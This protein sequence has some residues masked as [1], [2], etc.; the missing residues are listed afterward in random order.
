MSIC[1]Y[2]I[3]SY[4]THE[5]V[6]WDS[7]P[8]TNYHLHFPLVPQLHAVIQC[9]IGAV[10]LRSLGAKLPSAETL[11]TCLSLCFCG[12]FLNNLPFCNL[13]FCNSGKICCHTVPENEIH[14][15]ERQNSDLTIF[16][17]SVFFF[18]LSSDKVHRKLFANEFLF[19]S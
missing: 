19:L 16:K 5:N 14:Q 6:M 18:P 12:F 15:F 4:F 10:I 2:I 3:F 11:V 1:L 8:Q 13:T 7:S 9:R 17:D